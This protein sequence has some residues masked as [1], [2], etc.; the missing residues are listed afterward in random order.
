M[1][2][3]CWRVSRVLFWSWFEAG[4][5]DRSWILYPEVL[6]AVIVLVVKA[7]DLLMSPKYL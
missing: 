7:N 6:K 2:R 4:L 1:C 5:I 3:Q